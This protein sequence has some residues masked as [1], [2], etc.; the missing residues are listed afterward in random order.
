MS[1]A[2][3]YLADSHRVIGGS[4]DANELNALLLSSPPLSPRTSHSAAAGSAA[5]SGGSSKAKKLCTKCQQ[6]QTRGA[7]LTLADGSK[8]WLCKP[9]ALA[10]LESDSSN[11]SSSNA[12]AVNAP[13]LLRN[14]S[15]SASAVS[16]PALVA[17]H[18]K[19]VKAI[20]DKKY[21]VGR[22]TLLAILAAD[23][24]DA[25]AMYNVACCQALLG[26]VFEALTML[27]RALDAGYAN[28]EQIYSDVD[29]TEVR[30]L[31]GFVALMEQH[32]PTF[33]GDEFLANN[34]KTNLYTVLPSIDSLRGAALPSDVIVARS[35][36]PQR[37]SSPLSPDVNRRPRTGAYATAVDVQRVSQS[38]GVYAPMPDYSN[39]GTPSTWVYAGFPASAPP[40]TVEY[41]AL[42]QQT[43]STL[44]YRIQQQIDID[45]A[46]A[47]AKKPTPRVP[48]K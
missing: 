12:P 43:V 9:C 37:R 23:P 17:L 38:T 13:K 28:F 1:A 24:R 40:P 14:A 10:R 20:A 15:A 4:S 26:N 35:P 39:E 34:G 48:P 16:D 5:V 21:E 33:D 36:E 42:P 3:D 27:S 32:D 31:P 6:W 30:R 44:E 19:A 46:L 29:L 2:D 8:I 11:K 47:A 25:V 45:M 22:D 7:S 18:R 41:S